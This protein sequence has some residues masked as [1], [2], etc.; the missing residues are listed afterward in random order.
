V[1][2]RSWDDYSLGRAGATAHLGALD[3]VYTGVISSVREAIERVEDL[4]PITEDLL[5][6]QSG[7]LEQFHWFVRAHLENASGALSTTCGI[8]ESLCQLPECPT[9]KEV[10]RSPP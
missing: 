10:A 6:G 2:E 5:I 4:D 1:S 9:S 8:P 3:I 7:D